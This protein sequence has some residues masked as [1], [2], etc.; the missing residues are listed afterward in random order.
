MKPRATQQALID[1]LHSTELKWLRAD[2]A[3]HQSRLVLEAAIA[4]YAS[5]SEADAS[6]L[7]EAAKAILDACAGES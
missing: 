7:T 5:G 6:I 2:A 3:V 4:K 1:D